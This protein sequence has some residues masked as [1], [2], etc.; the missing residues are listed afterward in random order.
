MAKAAQCASKWKSW[1]G[2]KEGTEADKVIIDPWNKATGCHATSTKNPWCAIAVSSCL[3]QIHADGYSK[4]STCKNQKAYY[5][6]HKR[7]ITAGTR[8]HVGDVIFITGHEGTVTSTSPNGKGTYYS[9]NCANAVRPSSFNWK[10]MKAG[11]KSIQGYERPIW[12]A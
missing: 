1:K 12:K 6:K 7:W 3:I 5:K 9:G 8:P 11:K 2:I 4:S 10:T